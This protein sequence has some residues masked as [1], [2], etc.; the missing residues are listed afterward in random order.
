MK[1]AFSAKQLPHRHYVHGVDGLRALAVIGVIGYHLLPT[2]LP[3]GFLGVP[4]FLLISGYFVTGQL[5]RRWTDGKQLQETTFYRRRAKRLYPVL[6]T[7]LAATSVYILLFARNLL[8]HLRQII[9]TNLIGVYNWWEIYNG[10]S[11]FNRFSQQSPFTHLWTM[12][13]L[14]Q[15]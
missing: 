4:L 12:G 9:F 1:P 6:I 2:F 13:V 3:G 14:M 8:Y 5:L 7:I 11:Y 10:Q 15:F